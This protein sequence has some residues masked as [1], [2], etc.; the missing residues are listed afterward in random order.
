MCVLAASIATPALA[1]GT[2]T[3]SNSVAHASMLIG[4]P[5]GTFGPTGTSTEALGN[6]FRFVQDRRIQSGPVTGAGYAD[7]AATFTPSC[8]LG[9]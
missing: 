1:Q 5:T 7:L 8:P 6:D 4:S 3:F 2:V 9:L